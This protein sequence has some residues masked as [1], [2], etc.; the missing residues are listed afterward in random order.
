M[1]ATRVPHGLGQRLW[2]DNITRE[3]LTTGAQAPYRLTVGDWAHLHPKIFNLALKSGSAHGDA[4]RDKVWEGKS[5]VRKSSARAP[6]LLSETRRGS[7]GPRSQLN[8]GF[9][10]TCTSSERASSLMT[11]KA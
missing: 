8:P 9:A 7:E 4:I 5:V 6:N 3:L 2:L 1:K 11:A 10:M